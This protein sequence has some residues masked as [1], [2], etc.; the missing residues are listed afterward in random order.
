MTY[1]SAGMHTHPTP[2]ERLFY[3][4]ARVVQI[5]VMTRPRRPGSWTNT[6]CKP[7]KDGVTIYS[8][9]SPTDHVFMT[10]A[11]LRLDTSHN[12]TDVGPNATEDGPRWR[13]LDH[14][15]TWAHWSVRHP[16]GL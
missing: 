2:D 3:T 5:S 8:T 4:L 11:G 16:P 12:G 13:V 1:R 7:R 15:P 10:M 6:V 9:T 14:I